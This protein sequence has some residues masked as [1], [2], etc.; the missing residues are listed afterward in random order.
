MKRLLLLALVLP[1]A[2]PAAA[3]TI[4]DAGKAR[5]V[6]ALPD[7]PEGYENESAN[8]LGTYL[9][10]LTEAAFEQ[11]AEQDLQGRP[12]IFVGATAA[13][14][15]AGISAAKMDR[16]G[17]IIKATGG[18][19]YV[20]GYDTGATELG[21]HFFL[22]RYGG[23][24]WY[25]P[26]EI[27]EY[28][29]LRPS[30]SVPD[31]LDDRQEP[32]W[33]SRLWS[34]VSRMDPMWEKRNL[35]RPRYL[36]H[37]NLLHALTP[38]V[39]YDQHPD[40]YPLINGQRIPKPS[41]ASEG[42][43][44]CFSNKA[45][46]A[47]VAQEII[48]YFDKNPTATSFSLGINDCGA[49][50]YCQCDA[51]RAL[52][53]PKEPTYRDRPNYSNRVFTF[54]N[55]VAEITS[56]KHP[57]KLL[58][59]LSY[60]NC[61]EVPTFPVH[62]NIIPY[63]TNDRAQWRD[64]AFKRQDQDLLRRWAKA[65]RQLGV[66]DYYYGSGYIIPRF[67]PAVS[68]ESI[69]FCH[70]IGVRAWYA[71]IYSN[72]GLDGCKAWVA[73]Q[74]L[75]DVKQDP[76]KLVDE[77]YTNFFGA[78]KAPMKKYWDRCEQ[79]WMKQGGEAAW[80]KGFFQIGQLDMFPPEVCAELRGYLDRAAKLADTDLVRKRVKLYSDGFR[81]TELYAGAYW[82][83]KRMKQV[84][85]TSAADEAKVRQALVSYAVC[86]QGLQRHF[87][88]VI[89]KDPLLAPVIPFAGNAR[90]SFGE[91][92]LPAMARLA[93]YYEKS[94]QPLKEPFQLSPDLPADNPVAKM[95]VAYMTMR[96]HPESAQ[97]KMPN[98]GF[99]N[100]AGGAAPVGPEW[101]SEGCPP[102]WGS[103]V[104]DGSKAELRWVASPVHSGQ[105]AVMLK[106][107]EG[108]ACYLVTIAGQP[109]DVYLC[110]VYV[111]GKV[112]E[113]ER[114]SLTIKWHDPK[115][116]WY[117]GAPNLTMPLPQSELKDWTPLGIMFTMPAGAGSAVVMLAGGDMKPD[118][119][120]Y[121][122]DCS[123]KQLGK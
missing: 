104:R 20:V 53:D 74:L 119:V 16:D 79:V 103:W 122:D 110:T 63:L 62:P 111:R 96:T 91:G 51:C 56:Q 68:A 88:E 52:D 22:Q 19:L 90:S 57:D 114:V 107:A 50:G 109:G 28:I 37:H 9:G 32:S 98:P 10:K 39:V 64:P 2:L 58:G 115:G 29:P 7:K 86:E 23:I 8:E 112:Q 24:R 12:A 117:D 66:Y 105:R 67:Y 54:M 80:F 99:E 11:V 94:G 40:W 44:P 14:A 41:D 61:E 17:F 6:I 84:M 45:M 81:Y 70:S 3:L 73:S 82:G 118:D 48:D 55:R 75:W 38:S 100:Q 13:A 33:K 89:S 18:S 60:A 65:A 30:F 77:Y 47:W 76:K 78:A 43:Q 116:A 85:V 106:G 93:D 1:L 15:K 36:F 102:G 4:S 25:I 83:D 123:V 92:L 121:F 26:L 31:T 97:E 120:A 49:N 95:F 46:A 59:C 35:C 87:D 34:S 42:W 108:A 27:G 69:K 113:P 5:L 72:W 21:V 71:E 101:T